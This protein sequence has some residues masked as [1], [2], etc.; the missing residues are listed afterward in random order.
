[1]KTVKALPELVLSS[2]RALLS[3]NVESQRV[4]DLYK[5]KGQSLLRLHEYQHRVIVEIF[6]ISIAG[7]MAVALILL[8]FSVYALLD[9]GAPKPLAL[10][11]AV[12]AIVLMLAV[13]RTLR[14]FRS[15]RTNYVELTDRLRARL[16]QQSGSLAGGSSGGT[17]TVQHRLLSALRPKEHAGWDHKSCAK[18][19]KSIELLAA[20]CQHC[21][22]EQEALFTN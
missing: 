12:L 19:Q 7:F 1:M 5:G 4:S 11:V 22:H 13:Y 15:Y 18:C 6:R 20:L 16:L 21:G 8:S 17:S 9:Q 2:I 3:R 14:E 10:V